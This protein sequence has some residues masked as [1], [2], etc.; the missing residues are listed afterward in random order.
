MCSRS[1]VERCKDRAETQSCMGGT[2]ET[3][4]RADEHGEYER[5]GQPA[6]R[7]STPFSQPSEQ[8]HSSLLH[9]YLCVIYQCR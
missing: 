4:G 7:C 5:Q 1:R 3:S 9:I 2:A 6:Q 8:S